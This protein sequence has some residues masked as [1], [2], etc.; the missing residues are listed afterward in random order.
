[1]SYCLSVKALPENHVSRIYHDHVYGVPVKDDRLLFERL[2]MEINQA[3]LSWLTILKKQENF[4]KAFDFYD[5][6]KIANYGDKEIERLLQD[7]G[8]IRNRLKIEAV[9][10]NAKAVL[11]LMDKH[12]SFKAWLELNHPLSL[13]EWVKLFRKTFKFMGP[14]IVR[15][16]LV[17]LAYLP[18]AHDEFCHLGK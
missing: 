14:E 4:K 6:R 8:I 3:G 1:M 13:Q 7:E 15:E 10:F 16:F 17:S 11:V 18:G 9:I 12:G 2:V 5:I